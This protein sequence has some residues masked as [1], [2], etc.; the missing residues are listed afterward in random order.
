MQPVNNLFLYSQ[1]LLDT[2]SKRLKEKSLV[3]SHNEFKDITD[4]VKVLFAFGYSYIIHACCCSQIFRLPGRVCQISQIQRE[5]LSYFDQFLGY[6]FLV[7]T[8]DVSLSI[9]FLSSN[10]QN[11]LYQPFSVARQEFSFKTNCQTLGFGFFRLTS[12]NSVERLYTCLFSF[13]YFQALINVMTM[14]SSKKLVGT[15]RALLFNDCQKVLLVYTKGCFSF[16]LQR[17]KGVRVLPNLVSKL[18]TRSQYGL[19]Q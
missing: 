5:M 3:Y 11:F 16:A 8:R 14:C 6:Y 9:V 12:L 10:H 13:V 7:G 17:L 18:D 2:L 15:C 4:I 19:L 1:E